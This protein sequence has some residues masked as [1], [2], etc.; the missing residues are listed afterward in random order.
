MA[1][2][3][4]AIFDFDGTLADTV[5]WFAGIIN[6]VA[7]RFGFKRVHRDEYDLLRGFTPTEIMSHLD[8]PFWRVPAIAAYVKRR[9]AEEIDEVALVDGIA[10]VLREL[11]DADVMIAVVSS[12]DERTVRQI[13]GPE[14]VGLFDDFE[15]GV[16][17]FGKSVKL[18][19]VLRHTRIPI[20]R[21]IYVGD[22]IRDI[23]AAHDVGMHFGAVS[24]GYNNPASFADYDPEHVFREVD[25]IVTTIAPS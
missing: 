16:A 22:E 21:A 13:L 10:Q 12:N 7:D 17:L 14:L 25:D 1:R 2:Y 9:L 18:R 24:W 5:P 8:I 3:E 11:W 15:C 6:E 4:L 20:E 19:K 23:E